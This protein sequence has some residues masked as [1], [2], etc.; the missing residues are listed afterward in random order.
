[1][2]VSTVIDRFMTGTYTV[3]RMAADSY[4]DGLKVDGSTSTFTIRAGVQPATSQEIQMLPEGA[5][6]EET[7][8]V[9]TSTALKTGGEGAA[10]ERD[11]ISIDGG[12]WDVKA[13][14]TW[15]PFPAV[16]ETLYQCLV[17]AVAQ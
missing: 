13:V 8:T 2:Q 11:R 9:Y 16:T 7:L 10:T 3:T 14:Q 15:R 6:T 5:R 12:V 17:Q 1:M 4:V